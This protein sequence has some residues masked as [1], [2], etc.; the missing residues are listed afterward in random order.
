MAHSEGIVDLR[1]QKSLSS[2]ARSGGWRPP[3]IRCPAWKGVPGIKQWPNNGSQRRQYPRCVNL[4]AG[5]HKL[6]LEFFVSGLPPHMERRERPKKLARGGE[7][8][9]RLIRENRH[10]WNILR[11]EERGANGSLEEKPFV[12]GGRERPSSR[13]RDHEA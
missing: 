8:S 13:A 5:L 10:I 6:D 4:H 7:I 2:R 11:G 3:L 12:I 1:H 9:T